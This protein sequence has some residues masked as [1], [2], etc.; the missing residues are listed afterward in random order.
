MVK[1]KSI[2]YILLTVLFV[3]SVNNVLAESC[4]D[5]WLLDNSRNMIANSGFEE[6]PDFN[7]WDKSTYPAGVTRIIDN[8]NS[9]NGDVSAK[10][11]WD[12]SSENQNYFHECQTF[13]VIPGRTFRLS[14]YIKTEGISCDI[15]GVENWN[16]IRILLYAKGR[17]GIESEGIVTNCDG[18]KK[19]S[20]QSSFNP[21]RF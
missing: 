21:C 14:G 13:N 20:K 4:L 8:M 3:F 5:T 17:R 1:K 18:I 12:G 11:T 7:G 16:G 15:P 6:I 2:F 10:V 19:R 9:N